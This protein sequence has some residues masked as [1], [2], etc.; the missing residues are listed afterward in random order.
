MKNTRRIKSTSISGTIETTE[1][2]LCGRSSLMMSCFDRRQ[3]KE[4]DQLPIPLRWSRPR[5]VPQGARRRQPPEQPRSGPAAVVKS[6]CQMPPA[7]SEALAAPP[8][9]SRSRKAWIIPRTVPR[10][11][12]RGL[13]M[14]IV[15]T[16]RMRRKNPLAA[17]LPSTAR[18]SFSP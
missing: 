12:K 11:P 7:R 15:S 6:A 1:V 4:A 13:T 10:S 8:D 3:L 14:A 2:C 5:P 9:I 17:A 16:R 18:A